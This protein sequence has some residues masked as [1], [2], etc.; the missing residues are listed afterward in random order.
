MKTL[1]RFVIKFTGL[2]VAVLSCFD[3][4]IFKGYLPITNGPAL[5]GFVDYILKIR[6]CEFMAFA[7]EQSEALVGNAK[8]LAQEAG[9]EY[10]FLQGHQRKDKL[11][12][13][14]LRLQPI[15]DG[16]ICVLC[17][18]ETC[19]SFKLVRGKDRP[20]LV[21]ARRPQRVLYFYFLDPKL[22]LIYV[23][24]TTWFPFT[25]Q[26]YVN[27]HSWLAQ[28]MLDR[29]IGFN[30]RDNA[31]TALDDVQSAQKLADSFAHLDWRKIL[32]RLVRQVNP[33][34][35]GR[36]FRGYSYYWVIDQAEY[37]TD[38]IFASRDTLAGLYS[39]LLNHAVINFSAKDILTF[40][41]RRFH[42]RFD[43]EVLT[44]CQKNRWPGAR[45][46]H[47]M[48]NNWLKMYDKFGLVLRIETV[49]NN[50]REFHVR[51]W[52]TRAGHREIAWCPMNKGV[53]N[54]YRYREVALAAN[55]RYL[56]ALSVVENPAPAYRQVEK[57][58]EPVVKAGRSY[59]GFNPA[60]RPDVKLFGAV[61]DG[62]HVVR[63]FRNADIRE[64]LYGTTADSVERRRQSAAIGR[65]LKRL[66]VRG[67]IR[68][69]QR[70]RRWLVTPNG[71][72]VLQ[73][74]LQ[75]YHRGIPATFTTAA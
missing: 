51:S 21:N 19:P 4:V 48:K 74:V 66:H 30:L 57:I 36:W 40:L 26:I 25:V 24:L 59:A 60:S 44:S 27:G 67:L 33:L 45:I 58:T 15:A 7:E 14:I 49:I 37:A 29:R 65:L 28:Q 1:S 9:A 61:L 46:K 20:R 41:G 72:R 63:G 56:N 38:L 16:L 35:K 6:R 62:D 71:H 2:I 69:V 55:E 31:F 64:A 17:C 8:R 43:G 50:P 47:R 52:R 12:D 32:N 18:M 34:M 42:P 5:E 39:R 75:L 13:E 53:I 23:R 11:V 3:R 22:G 70:R 68:K 10:R 54:L 73:G